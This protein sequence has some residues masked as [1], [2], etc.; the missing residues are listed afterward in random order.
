MNAEAASVIGGD[1]ATPL[2]RV[3]VRAGLLPAT[4][5]SQ[6][7]IWKERRVELAFEHDRYF[8]LV[9]QGRAS[10]VLNSKGIPFVEG[11]HEVFPIP[12]EQIDKSGGLLI[13][14]PNY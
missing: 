13:Q 2:N 11:K 5:L 10:Q 3:R 9:R 14:N 4:D 6:E 7:A 12:Q 8:D 1:V